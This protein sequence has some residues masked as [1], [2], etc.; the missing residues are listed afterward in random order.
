VSALDGKVAVVTGGA[1]GIGRAIAT[2]LA[3]QGARVVVAMKRLLEPSEV[4]AYATFRRSD[5][6]AG[7]TGSLQVIDCGW[8]A[9]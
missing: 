5:S 3:A 7:I 8:T 1:S 4:A 2:D 6:A 9:R